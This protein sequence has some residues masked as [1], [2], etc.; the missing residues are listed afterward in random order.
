MAWLFQA[1]KPLSVST[2]T[3]FALRPGG[4]EIA[5]TAVEYRALWTLAQRRGS[6]SRFCD[7]EKSVWGTS[8]SARRAAL[9]QVI[10]SLRRKLTGRSDDQRLLKTERCIGYRL[11]GG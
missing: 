3:S 11:L 5:L 1:A 9:R 10:Q 2:C 4:R 8:S 7:L 6:V